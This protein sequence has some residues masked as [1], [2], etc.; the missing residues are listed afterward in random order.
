MSPSVLEEML[1]TVLKISMWERRMSTASKASVESMTKSPKPLFT[2]VLELAS[3][4]TS[5]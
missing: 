2:R 4:K 1:N 5:G 3:L